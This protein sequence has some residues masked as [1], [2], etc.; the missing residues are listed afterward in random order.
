MPS[1]TIIAGVN[2]VGKSSLSGILKSERSDLGYIVDVDRISAEQNCSPIDAARKAIKKIDGFLAQGISFSQETTLS[3][4]RIGRTIKNAKERGY[5]VRLFYIG[6]NTPDESMK[7]IHNRV[8]KGGHNVGPDD[9]MRRFNKRFDDLLK[10]MPFCDEA[11]M[12]DNENG[13]VE[14]AEY[15]NG[16]VITKGNYKPAWLIELTKNL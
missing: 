14:V 6:L 10:I 1:Y 16:E 13:F 11:R 2:G 7:R 9:V 3:G 12:F 8:E 4:Y 15:K 5:T